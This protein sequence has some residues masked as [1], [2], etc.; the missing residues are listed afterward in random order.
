MRQCRPAADAVSLSSSRELD[1]ETASDLTSITDIKDQNN[2]RDKGGGMSS[3]FLHDFLM[4]SDIRTV[5]FLAALMVLF[6]FI[7]RLQ[8]AQVSFT[9][10]V[11]IGTGLGLVLGLVIQLAA[12]F[13]RQPME[14][15]FIAETTRWYSLFGNGFIDLIR[16]LVVPLIMI[17]II[18][19]IINME[20]G[21]IGRL[22]KLTLITTMLMVT[23]AAV[24]GL[25]LGLAFNLGAGFAAGGASADIKQIAPV[26]D[27]LL[28]L[29]PANP[30]E[31][32]VQANIIGL[33]I[34][35]AFFGVAARRMAVKYADAVKPFNDLVNA[36]HKVV[37]SVAMAVIKLM[38]FAVIAMLANTI[39]Q[40]G[41]AHILDVVLF[42]GVLY[43]GVGAMFVVQFM[44]LACFG[45]NPLT[46][47]KKSGPTLLMAFTS[48]SS[49]GTLPMTLNT[50]T[51]RLGVSEGTAN[52]VASFGTTAGM[53]G[54]AGVFPALLIVFVANTSGAPLDITFLIMSV[55]VIAIGS[56]G[57][58]GIPGTATMAASVAL[59]GTGMAAL[60]PLIGP[61]LAIDPI[62]DMGR[63]CLNV[64]GGMVNS[65]I[66]DQRLGLLNRDDYNNPALAAAIDDTPSALDH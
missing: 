43:L 64:S 60:F 42:I 39:A 22:T 14:V 9:K 56:L 24:V 32:M 7:W 1:K 59:H 8:R 4:I 66:V 61:I 23:V 40:R 19:V 2:Q 57:I 54:C 52:F 12:G 20:S 63:S 37:I 38:P 29:V 45:L 35:A 51:H 31:A 50:L 34:F 3:V 13:P 44:V 10:R 48:R 6:Y 15:T 5:I 46:Y 33:V 55:M 28:A 17:S 62:I 27:T 58:A 25:G 53:Q 16:M 49:V 21:N 41:V 18:H 30:V 47:L 36:L 11:L 26:A 65:L